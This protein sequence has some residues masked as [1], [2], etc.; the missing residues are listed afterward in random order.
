MEANAPH[1]SAFPVQTTIKALRATATSCSCIDTSSGTIQM[2]KTAM[3]PSSAESTGSDPAK[4]EPESLAVS[5]DG[6]ALIVI[7]AGRK[8]RPLKASHLRAA[9]QCA[10][11]R[12]ARI[13]GKFPSSFDGVTIAKLDSMGHY[14]V[15]IAFSDDHARGIYPWSLL[16]ELLKE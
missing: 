2:G 10:H 12:R 3:P 6:S 14:G 8:T 9:C 1:F 13:D 7:Y 5:N 4:V 11:C 15:N 16:A